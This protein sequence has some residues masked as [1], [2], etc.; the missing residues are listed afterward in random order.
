A[1]L[2]VHASEMYSKNLANFLSL[3]VKDGKL[4]PD[5]DD[6]I[7]SASVVT[8]AGEIRHEQTRNR[9]EEAS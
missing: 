2:P 5:W 7:L 6:E 4:E 8:H 3:L 9:V 1:M